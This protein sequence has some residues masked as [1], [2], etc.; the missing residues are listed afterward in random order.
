M[1]RLFD[2]NTRSRLLYILGAIK[3]KKDLGNN[4]VKLSIA[5]SQE[6]S[7]NKRLTEIGGEGYS[8][9]FSSLKAKFILDSLTALNLFYAMKSH[10][11]ERVDSRH[12]NETESLLFIEPDAEAAI[13]YDSKT[14]KKLFQDGDLGPIYKSRKAQTR[15]LPELQADRVLP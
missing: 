7:Y 4:A 11:L 13:W 6:V 9:I 12:V 5:S 2:P 14:L 10:P 3:V 8:G 15:E 1:V